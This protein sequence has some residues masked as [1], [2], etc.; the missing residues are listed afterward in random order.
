MFLISSRKVKNQLEIF[1][2]Q[3]QVDLSLLQKNFSTIEFR[4]HNQISNSVEPCLRI[5]RH[6]S[7]GFWQ[8]DNNFLLQKILK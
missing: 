1:H 3:L 6:I 4:V 2:K 8:S 7:Q 5:K